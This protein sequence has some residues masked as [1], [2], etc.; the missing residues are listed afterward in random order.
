[1]RDLKQTLKDAIAEHGYGATLR[2]LGEVIEEA[3]A[4]VRESHDNTL[5]TAFDYTVTTLAEV[6]P[7]VNKSQQSFIHRTLAAM[8]VLKGMKLRKADSPGQSQAMKQTSNLIRSLTKP[9]S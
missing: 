3:E 9:S 8:P 2:T 5:G 4:V 6:Y 1:M 7:K